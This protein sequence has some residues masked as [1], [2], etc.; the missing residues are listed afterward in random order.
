MYVKKGSQFSVT[1][2]QLGSA[3]LLWSAEPSPFYEELN[4]T[5]KIIDGGIG[6]PTLVTFT[7]KCLTE[8]QFILKLIYQRPFED[9]PVEVREITF[10]TK[11][12]KGKV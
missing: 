11:E 8:R 10:N 6:S 5:N 9:E 3:G 2:E 7:F 1:V 12:D 4:K